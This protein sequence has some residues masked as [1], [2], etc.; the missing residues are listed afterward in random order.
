MATESELTAL[1]CQ[2]HFSTPFFT[3]PYKIR[4]SHSA[5]SNSVPLFQLSK[6][7]TVAFVDLF[8]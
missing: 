5:N 2:A 3:P 6:H 8:A 7:S 4:P 1:I